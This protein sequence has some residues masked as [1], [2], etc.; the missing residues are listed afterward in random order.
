MVLVF[1]EPRNY[2][3]LLQT[4]IRNRDGHEARRVGLVAYLL[5]AD[6]DHSP[7]LTRLSGVNQP[8]EA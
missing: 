8:V 7:L 6:N 5:A 2:I 1:D 3:S 4:K